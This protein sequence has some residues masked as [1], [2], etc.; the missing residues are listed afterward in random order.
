MP[1]TRFTPQTKQELSKLEALLKQKEELEKQT[2]A[3][4]W[5]ILDRRESG[6]QTAIGRLYK[7]SR[8]AVGQW[9]SAR[10]AA[11]TVAHRSLDSG[12]LFCV[13]C[14]PSG[15]DALESLFSEDLPE[16][17]VCSACGADVLA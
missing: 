2:E 9:V 16:G 17:G 12:Q 6:A 14:A 1:P 5:A 15:E 7:V 8:S 11:R 3:L 10:D 4:K 13:R